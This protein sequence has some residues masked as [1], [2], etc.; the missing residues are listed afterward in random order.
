MSNISRRV[1]C[2]IKQLNPPAPKPPA[3]ANG[4]EG[5]S[6]S[7]FQDAMTHCSLE[8]LKDCSFPACIQ[9]AKVLVEGNGTLEALKK[10]VE[11]FAA[12]YFDCSKSPQPP[13]KSSKSLM[14]ASEQLA[15]E[16]A[17]TKKEKWT[18]L[19]KAPLY[20]LTGPLLKPTGPAGCADGGISTKATAGSSPP[21]RLTI[22]KWVET[23]TKTSLDWLDPETPSSSPGQPPSKSPPTSGPPTIKFSKS[24]SADKQV[25]S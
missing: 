19:N 21:K 2:D 9:I 8:S 12:D 5:L 6:F 23:Y 22:S 7:D 11:M 3:V 18:T 15:Y 17:L 16:N 13:I 20:S 25:G 4:F 14:E 1:K 10:Q 24:D